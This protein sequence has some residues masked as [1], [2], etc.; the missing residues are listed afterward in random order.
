M[1]L[2]Y[3]PISPERQEQVRALM[4]SGD[5]VELAMD[6]T[7]IIG[8]LLAE[9]DRKDA[10]LMRQGRNI[11]QLTGDVDLLRTYRRQ[12]QPVVEAALGWLAEKNAGTE[13]E[14]SDALHAL[15]SELMDVA[16]EPADDGQQN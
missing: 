13:A 3:E 15:V 14:L 7:A 10:V 6:A 12:S 9:L 11:G 1:S 4:A 2:T 5:T 16:I 8:G